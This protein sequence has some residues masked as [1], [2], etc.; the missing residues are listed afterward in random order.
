ME[1]KELL[2]NEGIYY[3]EFIIKG[4]YDYILLCNDI[5]ENYNK[6]EKEVIKYKNKYEES[7]KELEQIKYTQGYDTNLQGLFEYWYV[8]KNDRIYKKEQE[9]KKRE[10]ILEKR[11]KKIKKLNNYLIKK[12]KVYKYKNLTKEIKILN[13]K[14]RI[15]R[16]KLLNKKS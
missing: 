16:I 5:M 12:E 7:K 1:K 13:H 10:F 11:E 4:D 8:D 15:L 9:L 6:L 2:I 3:N 14:N